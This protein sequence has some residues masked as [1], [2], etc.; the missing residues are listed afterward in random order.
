MIRELNESALR[1]REQQ[2]RILADLIQHLK[3]EPLNFAD[4]AP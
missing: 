2:E 1:Q 3:L 4:A